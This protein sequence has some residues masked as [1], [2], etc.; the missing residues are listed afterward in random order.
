MKAHKAAL[1]ALVILFA[2]ASVAWAQPGPYIPRDNSSS[3]WAQEIRGFMALH[4]GASVIPTFMADL[5]DT[6]NFI[7]NASNMQPRQPGFAAGMGFIPLIGMNGIAIEV[8]Y[9][10]QTLDFDTTIIDH[11]NQR[12]VG[13]TT[14]Q[15]HFITPSVGYY[16]YFLEGPWHLHILGCLGPD[17]ETVQYESR[18]YG[19]NRRGESRNTNMDFQ[20]GFGFLYA[21][22]G[23]A[24]GAEAR[25]HFPLFT[26]PYRINGI[27]DS[28][29]M[30]LTV[31][32]IIKLEF[33]LY[34]G[35]F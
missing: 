26:D 22:T 2:T 3:P 12:Y 9:V 14:L 7:F 21:F 29:T 27:V 20:T 18:A 33:A 13:G 16:R 4:A 10:M 28:Y 34:V 31:P 35:N 23:G 11:L 19:K 17:F 32:V 24:V 6:K 30:N 5:K 8:E 25:G 15:V 1:A